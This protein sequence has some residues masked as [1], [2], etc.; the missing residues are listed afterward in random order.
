MPLIH[1]LLQVTND[2][3]VYFDVPKQFY[4]TT[5]LVFE[6]FISLLPAKM[7]SGG[8]EGGPKKP[9]SQGGGGGG[10]GGG[11]VKKVELKPHPVMET[12]DEVQYCVQSPPPWCQ[13]FMILLSYV[14]PV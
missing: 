11:G 6:C 12:L 4:H 9:E 10:G 8:G 2:P 1:D 5:P 3:S 14:F 7:S 13:F